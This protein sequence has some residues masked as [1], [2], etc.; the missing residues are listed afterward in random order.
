VG[1]RG[2]KR[3]RPLKRSGELKR[4][5]GLKRSELGRKAEVVRQELKR[6]GE[7]VRKQTRRPKEG[8]LSPA[9]WRRAVF[10]ASGGR[11]IITGARARDA[12]DRRFHAHHLVPKREL[13]ARRLYGRVWDPRNGVWLRREVHMRHEDAIERVPAAALPASVWQ[14]CAELDALEGTEWATRMVLRAHPGSR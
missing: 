14:F 8:P 6:T 12:E 11:C 2:V 7:L 4:T 5:G 10:D 9:E 3:R 13:R 1:G